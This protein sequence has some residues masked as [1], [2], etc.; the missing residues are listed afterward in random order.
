LQLAGHSW[1]L[2][3][4]GFALFWQ[5]GFGGYG[6]KSDGCGN[7]RSFF[8]EANRDCCI[9]AALFSTQIACALTSSIYTSGLMTL[10]C[11][12]DGGHRPISAAGQIRSVG[13][14]TSVDSLF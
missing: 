6:A 12:R 14:N 11:R 8:N 2:N 5:Q 7:E 10:Q 9:G 1:C 4:L 13:L 3:R